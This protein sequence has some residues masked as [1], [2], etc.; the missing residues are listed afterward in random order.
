[1]LSMACAKWPAFQFEKDLDDDTDGGSALLRIKLLRLFD[2]L[3]SVT[4]TAEQMGQSG[5]QLAGSAARAT[6]R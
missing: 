6:G 1:M 3:Y 2:L 4:R 5:Q